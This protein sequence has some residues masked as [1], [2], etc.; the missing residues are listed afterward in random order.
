MSSADSRNVTKVGVKIDIADGQRVSER[1]CKRCGVSRRGRKVS[2][3]TCF[4]VNE[5][6]IIFAYEP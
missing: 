2:R 1:G 6:C 4:D 5:K 3:D